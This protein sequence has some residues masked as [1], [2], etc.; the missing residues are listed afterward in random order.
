MSEAPRPSDEQTTPVHDARALLRTHLERDGAEL[1]LVIDTAG[2]VP[3]GIYARTPDTPVDAYDHR[4]LELYGTEVA[5]LV[6]AE[7]GAEA[8]A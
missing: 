3:S 8:A 1:A 5:P 6:R 4:V 2:R 7:L